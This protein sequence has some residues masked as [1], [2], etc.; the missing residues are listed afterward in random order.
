LKT[1]FKSLLL[2]KHHLLHSFLIILLAQIPGLLTAQTGSN[3]ILKEPWKAQWIT[4]NQ[5]AP[6]GMNDANGFGVYKFRK[7]ITLYSKPSSFIVHVSADNRYKLYVN[8][9]LVALGPARGDLYFWN[10]ETIDI[11]ATGSTDHL[12][13][14][15]HFARR[16]SYGSCV[17]YRYILEG[18]T[19][20]QL[21]YIS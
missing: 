16:F 6:T 10:F 9:K 2:K 19:R 21:C 7:K 13:D 20:Q 14:R 8:E 15:L 4:V 1:F 3:A 12:Q 11:A 18:H 17:E 5:P